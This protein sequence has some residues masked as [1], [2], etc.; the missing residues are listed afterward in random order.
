MEL[1]LWIVLFAIGFIGSMISG[2][3]GIGGSIIKYPM[4]LYLPPLFG[5]TAYTAQEVSA[6]SAIQ[7]FFATI[8]GV[9][10]HR[11][12]GLI[13]RKLVLAMGIPILIAGWV[14]GYGSAWLD[15]QTIN[16]I[17]AILAFVAAVMMLLP[18]TAIEEADTE[19]VEVN[20]KIAAGF[21]IV[22]GLVSGIVGA[23]GAFITVPVMFVVLRIPTR[24][25][26]ASS[27]LITFIASIGTTAGKLMGGHLLWEPSV[28]MIIASLLAAPVGV[29]LSQQIRVRA[30]QWVL[31]G[32]IGATVVKIWTDLLIN[33]HFF[34]T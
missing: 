9:W 15:D 8:A 26:I 31:T 7:V 12:S 18:K 14:G 22:I 32:I 11:K 16:L 19:A 34:S 30:L 17:Y 6:I 2:M 4:L 5:L 20:V 27:L 13:H 25:A 28:I 33:M 10:A 21:A 3:V 1:D 24:I 23:A 29:W